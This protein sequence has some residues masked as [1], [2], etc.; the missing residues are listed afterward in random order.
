MAN[1]TLIFETFLAPAWYKTYQYII[2]YVERKIGVPSFLLN[3]E[4]LDD[5]AAVDADAGFVNALS[6]AQLLQQKPCPIELIASPLL[7]GE[8]EQDTSRAVFTIVVHKGSNLKSINDLEGCVWAYHGSATYFEEQY[9]YEQGVP[10][11]T[12][13]EK[14]ETTSQGQ[15]LRLV[16]D[17][18]ADATAIDAQMLQLVLHNS[19]HMAAQLHVLGTNGY[20]EGPLVVIATH[21]EPTLK[22]KIQE[23]LLTIHLDKFYAQILLESGIQRFVALTNEFYQHIPET[24]WEEPEIIQTDNRSQDACRK[25]LAL[26]SRS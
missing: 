23:A 6:Y 19:P 12:F 24:Q 15:A 20:A 1:S 11:I 22:R 14:I 9:S 26:L 4:T 5:F 10:L 17:G 7:K 21:V 25:D 13:K 16:L 8:D 3:G 2:E 18:K